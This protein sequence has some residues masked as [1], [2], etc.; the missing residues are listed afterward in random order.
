MKRSQA[1][2]PQRRDNVTATL[3]HPM[4]KRWGKDL[5]PKD[6]DFRSCQLDLSSEWQAARTVSEDITSKYKELG[7]DRPKDPLLFPKPDNSDMKKGGNARREA[8]P[9]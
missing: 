5:T 4:D 8:L 1:E 7:S 3:S 9:E 2:N 6:E